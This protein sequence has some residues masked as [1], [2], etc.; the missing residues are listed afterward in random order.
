MPIIPRSYYLS[1]TEER[2][3]YSVITMLRTGDEITQTQRIEILAQFLPV[4]VYLYDKYGRPEEL[5]H[6]D[7]LNKNL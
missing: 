6:K 5:K 3:L 7:I 2:T 4:Q 1:D